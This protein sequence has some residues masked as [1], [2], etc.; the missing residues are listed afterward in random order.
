MPYLFPDASKA[1]KDNDPPGRK[2]KGIPIGISKGMPIGLFP[3]P[4]PPDP[5]LTTIKAGMEIQFD[6]RLDRKTGKEGTSFI[7]E[8]YA[9][10]G[11]QLAA[12]GDVIDAFDPRVRVKGGVSEASFRL[13]TLKGPYSETLV[14]VTVYSKEPGAVGPQPKA[15]FRIVPS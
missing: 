10:Q 6:V 14:L 1:Q 13:R 8:L 2:P 4:P 9:V 5:F 3:A 15:F 11:D 7:V 12:P